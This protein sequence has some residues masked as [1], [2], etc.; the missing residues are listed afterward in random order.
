MSFVSF[1]PTSVQNIQALVQN[2]ALKQ[3]TDVEVKEKNIRVYE[4]VDKVAL[5]SAVDKSSAT[6]EFFSQVSQIR[7]I[8]VNEKDQIIQAEIAKNTDPEN[9]VSDFRGPKSES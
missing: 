7:L 9:L 2:N 1:N 8:Y 4:V 6:E 3:R 5:E